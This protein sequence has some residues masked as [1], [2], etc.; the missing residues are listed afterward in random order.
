[1]RHA[2]RTTASVTRW[3]EAPGVTGLGHPGH[4]TWISVR[5]FMSPWSTVHLHWINVPRVV[6]DTAAPVNEILTEA[7]ASGLESAKLTK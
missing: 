5:L 2:P 4:L 7:R 3:L 6:A 1:M